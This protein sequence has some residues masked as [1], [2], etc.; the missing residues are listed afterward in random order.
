MSPAVTDFRGAGVEQF[1]HRW[2]ISSLFILSTTFLQLAVQ[3]QHRPLFYN[4]A[5]Y[6]L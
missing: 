4:E 6:V 3:D 5:A 1:V 2:T